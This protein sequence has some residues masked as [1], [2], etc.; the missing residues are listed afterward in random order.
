MSLE[1]GWRCGGVI[2]GGRKNVWDGEIEE[3]EGRV[4]LEDGVCAVMA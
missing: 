1:V 3:K 2:R 4:S